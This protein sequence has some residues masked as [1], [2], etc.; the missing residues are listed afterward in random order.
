MMCLPPV[1]SSPPYIQ[2]AVLAT[3]LWCHVLLNVAAGIS[4]DSGGPNTLL[5]PIPQS[6]EGQS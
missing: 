3:N 2:D 1:S 5:T 4:R 6:H